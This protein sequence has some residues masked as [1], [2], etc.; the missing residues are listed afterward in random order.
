MSDK[1]KLTVL[2]AGSWGTAL[3]ALTARNGVPTRLW[4]RD[5]EALADVAAR[6]RNERYLPGVTLPETLHYEANLA[7]AVRGAKIVLI[8]HRAFG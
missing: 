5:A 1:P 3:A 8:V 6:R 4:G 7:A 2:G